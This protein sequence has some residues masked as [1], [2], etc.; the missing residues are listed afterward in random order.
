MVA[1]VGGCRDDGGDNDSSLDKEDYGDLLGGGGGIRNI[2]IW[3]EALE[4]IKLK[5]EVRLSNIHLHH[6][7][8]IK[9]MAR[10]FEDFF[11]DQYKGQRCIGALSKMKLNLPKGC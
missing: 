1:I 11:T 4:P 3:M 8:M 9:T 10:H 6:L 2:P 7:W 5:W